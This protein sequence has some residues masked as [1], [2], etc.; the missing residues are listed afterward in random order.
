MNGILETGV[1]RLSK[2]EKTLFGEGVYLSE[3]MPKV[4]EE[5]ILFN[6]YGQY[7]KWYTNEKADCYFMFERC[8]LEGVY[9]RTLKDGR[10]IWRYPNR[11]IYL[12]RIPSFEIGFTN[13]N[14]DIRRNQQYADYR[15]RELVKA[16]AGYNRMMKKWNPTNK[17]AQSLREKYPNYNCQAM[18]C[19]IYPESAQQRMKKE[20]LQ[21]SANFDTHI[22]ILFT[23]V[24]IILTMFFGL[25]EIFSLSYEKLIF[26]FT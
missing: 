3:L 23:L 7:R 25:K 20:E 14:R 1:I 19:K 13:P 26:S 12:D 5:A 9:S 21:A 11:N 4:G 8:E 10:V 22:C 17:P 2:Q 24:G 6:N 18:S 16:I 15:Q